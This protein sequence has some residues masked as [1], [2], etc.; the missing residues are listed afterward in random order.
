VSTEHSGSF[1]KNFL[2][3]FTGNSIGQVVPFLLAP[4]IARLYLPEQIA[5][6]ENF[7]AMA[8]LVGIIAAGRFDLAIL[9]PKEDKDAKTV[10]SLSF[11]ITICISALCIFSIFFSESIAQFYQTPILADY[12]FYLAP[13]VFLI[14]ALSILT[15][16]VL[17]QKQYPV[18]TISRVLQSFIQNGG[19]VVLGYLGWGIHG[20]FISWTLGIFIPV[21][22][23]FLKELNTF[24]P[25]VKDKTELKRLAIEHKDFPTVNSIHA[26]TDILA[27]QFLLYWLITR[28]HGALVLGLFAVMNRYL[29]APLNLV[30]SA[31]GQLYF[32]EASSLVGRNHEQI[33]IYYRSI[34]IISLF[35]VPAMLVIV[36]MGPTLF[37]WYLG[38]DWRDSGTFARIMAPAILFNF[39]ASVVSTTPLLLKQQKTAYI[40]SILGYVLSLGTLIIGSYLSSSFEEVLY[41]YSAVLSLYYIFLLI[42]YRSIILN[43]KL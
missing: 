2:I 17:R 20:L 22:W 37:E 33:Q 29:R 6:Q 18:M 40:L 26:F 9:L 23:M 11:I 8:S 28:N 42:W 30:G 38:K 7:L 3:L 39:L 27:T 25:F 19:Y 41:A 24:R 34:R 16:W 4:F 10:F 36:V 1:V 43:S 35:V 32:R 5:I 13:S 21:V 14:S 12:I 15:Q 31:V